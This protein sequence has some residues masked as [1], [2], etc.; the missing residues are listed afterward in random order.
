MAQHTI[1]NESNVA[2]LLATKVLSA[3]NWL[4]KQS[5]IHRYITYSIS[6]YNPVPH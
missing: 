2:W 5:R 1:Q 4:I 3:A 6:G